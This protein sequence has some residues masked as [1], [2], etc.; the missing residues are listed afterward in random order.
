M[1]KLSE[2]KAFAETLVREIVVM[3]GKAVIHYTLPIAGDSHTLEVD[4]E[5]VL[6]RGAAKSA[7]GNRGMA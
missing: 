5:E 2:R 4:S 1:W 7:V 3:P 6:L